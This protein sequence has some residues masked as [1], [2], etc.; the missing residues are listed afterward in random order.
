M[1][2][3]SSYN[4]KRAKQENRGTLLTEKSNNRSNNLDSISTS[5]LVDIFVDEDKKPQQAV[6]KAKDQII[7]FYTEN[8][9]ALASLNAPIFEEKVVNFVLEKIKVEKKEISRKELLKK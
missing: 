7:K 2:R 3:D 1:D 9:Q 6:S 5:E 8:S 4:L